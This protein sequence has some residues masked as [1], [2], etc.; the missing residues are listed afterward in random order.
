MLV[1]AHNCHHVFSSVRF[2]VLFL[3]DLTRIIV[4]GGKNG[5][6]DNAC[7]FLVD[8]LFQTIFDMTF[9]GRTIGTKA[10]NR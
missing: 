5:N 10:S 2:T 7:A 8:E 9:T 6:R 1:V 3:V 4:G